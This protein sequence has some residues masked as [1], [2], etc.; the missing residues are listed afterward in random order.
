MQPQPQQKNPEIPDADLI[1]KQTFLAGLIQYPMTD[2]LMTWIIL[3]GFEWQDR[4]QMRWRG[5]GEGVKKKEKKQTI[6][7]EMTYIQERVYPSWWGD[8]CCKP[9]RRARSK[10]R[11][12]RKHCDPSRKD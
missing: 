8:R 4:K 7:K 5:E 1:R 6:L 9:R 3:T 11:L 2:H 10:D 12:L